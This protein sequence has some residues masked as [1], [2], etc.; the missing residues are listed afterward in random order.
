M[1][2][3]GPVNGT[4]I[5]SGIALAS[6]NPLALDMVGAGLMGFDWRTIGY[7]WY[8]S[9]LEGVAREDIQVIGEDPA[10]WVT[11]YRAHDNTPWMLGWWV[12]N[13][14]EYLKGG[15]LLPS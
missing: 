8:L 11:K 4:P 1:E 6:V 12:Q 15:Y 14:R 2:G 7:M 10:K 13:W 5:N 9:Q 3:N